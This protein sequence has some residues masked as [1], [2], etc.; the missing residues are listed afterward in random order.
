MGEEEVEDT[1]CISYRCKS[2]LVSVRGI[3]CCWPL[4][5]DGEHQR[6]R[7]CTHVPEEGFAITSNPAQT[8]EVLKNVYKAI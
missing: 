2:S 5:M 1:V 7:N 8:Y 6:D 3:L 4:G